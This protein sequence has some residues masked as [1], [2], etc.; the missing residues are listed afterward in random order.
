MGRKEIAGRCDANALK[1]ILKLLPRHK[2]ST[3][4]DAKPI[5]ADRQLER[6]AAEAEREA[7]EAVRLEQVCRQRS[8]HSS[9]IL[10]QDDI[11]D[12]LDGVQARNTEARG[13]NDKV[14]EVADAGIDMDATSNPPPN[15]CPPPPKEKTKSTNNVFKNELT[16]ACKSSRKPYFKLETKQKNKNKRSD[17]IMLLSRHLDVEG[18]R[19]KG[20][21]CV[22]NNKQFC[23]DVLAHIDQLKIYLQQISKVN[24]STLDYSDSFW[25]Y[26]DDETSK[27]DE[28]ACD[29]LMKTLMGVV[30]DKDFMNIRKLLIDIMLKGDYDN[31][32]KKKELQNLF[33]SK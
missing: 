32:E 1:Q 11:Y 12:L 19:T 2:Y 33:Q 7:A 20:M 21:D 18:V 27:L 3:D 14:V 16:N 4:R 24:L 6:K 5:N 31:S 22:I 15:I 23:K 25:P 26:V 8:L 28:S 9:D 17:L 30:T 13:N 10:I 29:R